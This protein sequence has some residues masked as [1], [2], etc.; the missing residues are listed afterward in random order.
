MSCK[1]EQKQRILIENVQVLPMTGP[2]DYITRGY[3]TIEGQYITG[4]EAGCPKTREGFDRVIDGR[5]KVAMP[6]L[7]NAHTHVAMTLMRGYADDLPLMEWLETR[8]EPL[9]ARLTES[10]VYWGAMLGI[11]EMIKSGT[12]TFA[13]MYIFMDQ[14][15]RAVDE[16]GI[17]ASLSRGMNGLGPNAELAIT[18]SRE[19]VARWH[20]QAEERISIMIG[21]HAPYTCP[22]AYL[23]RVMALTGELGVGIHIHLAETRTEV[24]NIRR[25]YGRTPVALMADLGLFR[26]PVL[27]AHCVYLTDEEIQ[28]LAAN[29]VSVVHNP[30]SNMK[31][32]SGIARVPDLLRAGVTV[33]LGTDG[34]ASNNNLDMLEEVRA[35]A[36]I[37]K[38]QTLDPQVIPAYQALEMATV[39]GARALGLEGEVG[40]LRTGMK[41]DIILIN[42]EKPHLHP[43]HN[44]IAHLVYAAQSADIDTVIV[45][46]KILMEDKHVTTIDEERV[47]KEV[48]TVIAS[49]LGR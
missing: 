44:V 29:R 11:L 36:L 34:A 33:A 13:D 39:N 40:S 16:S 21:P 47:M 30:Q 28:V 18:Q 42:L 10:D 6:G 8:I 15:A 31:L 41:A 12:T 20:G 5:G 24:E 32:A 22:P 49:L 48:E 1:F 19:L 27:A 43:Q 46:G 45:N 3:I 37:H 7:I 26:Y 25:E 4:V 2:Q 9:E 17:R 35:C 23:E 14:V 38:V